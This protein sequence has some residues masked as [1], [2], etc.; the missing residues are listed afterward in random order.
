MQTDMSDFASGLGSVT[1]PYM[2]E[3][4][5]QL[6]KIHN[7]ADY[8]KACFRLANDIELS[9]PWVPIDGGFSGSLDGA[10]YTLSEMEFTLTEG[11]GG[12]FCELDDGAHIQSLRIHTS[13]NG[14]TN[15]NPVNA[16]TM[17]IGVLAG[18]VRHVVTLRNIVVAGRIESHDRFGGLI[19]SRGFI[20]DEAVIPIF[21]DHI[22]CFVELVNTGGQGIRFGTVFGW[23]YS[24]TM[25]LPTALA[26]I[27]SEDIAGT[28]DAI[29]LGSGASGLTGKVTD[30]RDTQIDDIANYPATWGD[31]AYIDE[32]DG[33]P[34]F[35][36]R[37][38]AASSLLGPLDGPIGEVSGT[39]SVIGTPEERPVIAIGYNSARDLA[40]IVGLGTSASDGTFTLTSPG[41]TDP[42]MVLCL[43]NAG[44]RWASLGTYSL[45][46]RTFASAANHTGLVYQCTGA[47]TTAATEPTWPTA[48]DGTVADGTVTWRAIEY[49]QPQAHGPVNPL[50]TGA[51]IDITENSLTYT[52]AGMELIE[53]RWIQRFVNTLDETDFIYRRHTPP[54]DISGSGTYEY[55]GT[56]NGAIWYDEYALSTDATDLIYRTLSLEALSAR[57][58][59]TL[60]LLNGDFSS[61]LDHWTDTLNSFELRTSTEPRPLVGDSYAHPG[62]FPQA[63]ARQTLDFGQAIGLPATELVGKTLRLRYGRSSWSAS[64]PGQVSMRFVDGA[65]AQ[66]GLTA[67]TLYATDPGK[68]WAILYLEAVVPAAT[69]KMEV[70]LY[71]ERT[72]GTNSDAYFDDIRLQIDA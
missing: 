9:K 27:V 72:A 57:Y 16:L 25:T 31:Y 56:H 33:Y 3:T 60:N 10:G 21:L 49:Y 17:Y 71:G 40:Q 47:G 8:L 55:T 64:D 65:D 53:D 4:S 44:Q 13:S 38:E 70:I 41:Y 59:I 19:G 52:Y 23:S 6:A 42:V 26:V 62:D 36:Q 29:G 18:R 68:T 67:D 43:D 34:A 7:D 1:S 63:Q 50:V 24:A 39:V 48:I 35:Y 12:L 32:D 45:G 66:T 61:G 2:I 51:P 46:D 69:T 5:A 20:S 14:L 37:P 15:S 30:L 28:S 58:P 11:F 22:A 54:D